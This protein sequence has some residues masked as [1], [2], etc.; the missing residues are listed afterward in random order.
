MAS[1]VPCT[2]KITLFFDSK[3]REEQKFSSVEALVAQ[4]RNDREKALEILAGS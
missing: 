1:K 4:L 3:I 2:G